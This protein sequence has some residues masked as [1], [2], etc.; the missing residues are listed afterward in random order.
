MDEQGLKKNG[1]ENRMLKKLEIDNFKSLVDFHMDLEPVT[2]VIGNN[3][4]GKSAIL[5]AIDF[6]CSSV[7]E[8]F[9]I[10]IERRN[11]AVENI[12]TIRT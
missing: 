4:T 11:W 10:I 9:P 6:L 7:R 2:V 3:A 12:I 5:Q 8:D 1:V